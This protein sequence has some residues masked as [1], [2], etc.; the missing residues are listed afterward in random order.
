MEFLHFYIEQGDTKNNRRLGD[1]EY[2]TLDP[3]KLLISGGIEKF[4]WT[5]NSGFF[6]I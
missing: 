6:R 1:L 3:G 2:K 5:C 4:M